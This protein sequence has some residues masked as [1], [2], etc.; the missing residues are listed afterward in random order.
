MASF[1]VPPY[2]IKA[3]LVMTSVSYIVQ[4][5]KV[6]TA[7][8]LAA[9]ARV[10]TVVD[11]SLGDIERLAIALVASFNRT[12]AE[13]LKVELAVSIDPAHGARVADENLEG[14]D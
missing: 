4:D 14:V 8:L 13:L 3:A 1:S 12:S 10:D 2:G 11:V 9:L 5:Q 7:Q 6:L